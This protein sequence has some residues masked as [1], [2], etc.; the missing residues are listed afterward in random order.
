LNTGQDTSLKVR[1]VE[2]TRKL[3]LALEEIFEIGRAGGYR[4]TPEEALSELDDM[5][6]SILAELDSAEIV[7]GFPSAQVRLP[8]RID[9][10]AFRRHLHHYA[11]DLYYSYQYP[12]RPSAVT[13]RKGAPRLSNEYLDQILKLVKEGRNPAQIALA[14]G[15]TGPGAKD[16][17]RKQIVTATN[18]YSAVVENI[19]RLG[20]AQLRRNA[21]DSSSDAPPP[22][23]KDDKT[24]AVSKA[25]KRKRAQRKI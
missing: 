12:R 14:L 21:I 2:L 23:F 13:P 22:S 19:R 7:K 20:A 8:I 6:H 3:E 9:F 11:V 24:V 18:R 15:L 10:V 5:L 17:V 16:R 25:P 4:F 1:K